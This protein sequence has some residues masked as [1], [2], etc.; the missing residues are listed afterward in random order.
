[1]YVMVLMNLFWDF[2]KYKHYRN[3]HKMT[4]EL[5]DN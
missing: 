4:C 1:M 5:G 2:K 3:G